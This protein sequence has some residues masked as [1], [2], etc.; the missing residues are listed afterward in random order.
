ME[1]SV[2]LDAP[3][4]AH[5]G[6]ARIIGQII[7]QTSFPSLLCPKEISAS[8][9]LLSSFLRAPKARDTLLFCLLVDCEIA[10]CQAPF[11]S[12]LLDYDDDNEVKDA[13]VSY[14]SIVM[15]PAILA[16]DVFFFL[17]GF[18][19]FHLTVI[20]FQKGHHP[21]S[22][23]STCTASFQVDRVTLIPGRLSADSPRAISNQIASPSSASL[24]FRSSGARRPAGNQK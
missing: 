23:L 5:N 3:G 4:G 7:G 18:L 9:L 20:N 24:K 13:F 15:L 8:P 14:A 21:V 19:G 6:P 22:V 2:Q 10:K 17:S 12:A 16:V 1:P 11:S